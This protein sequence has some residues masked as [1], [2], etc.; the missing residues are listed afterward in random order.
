M[1]DARAAPQ[2]PPARMFGLGKRPW[3][4]GFVV[5]ATV[6]IIYYLLG[7]LALQV[8]SAE[9]VAVFWPASGLAAGAMVVLYPGA[10]WP[11][12]LAVLAATAIANLQARSSIPA[13]VVF[14]LC[15]AA[16]CLIFGRVMQVL[17]R[18]RPHLESLSSVAAFLVAVMLAAGL[19]ALPAAYAIQHL[20]I[21]AA[22]LHNIWQSWFISD[23]IGILTLAPILMTLPAMNERPPR[24]LASLEGLAATMAAVALAYYAFGYAYS[25]I[26]ALTAPTTI[27]LPVSLWLAARTPA[28]YSAMT[29]FLVALVIVIVALIG[30][31]GFGQATMPLADR[32]ISAKVALIATSLT[33][34]TLSAMFARANATATAL[35]SSDQ[36][37][38]L[39]LAGGQIYAFEHDA[40]SRAVHREG[41]LAKRLGLPEVGTIDEYLD[42]LPPADRAAFDDMLHQVSPAEPDIERLLHL[43]SR[44]GRTLLVEYRSRAE[45]DAD[46]RV[47][48]IR[49]T[50]HDITDRERARI[51]KEERE[52][53]VQRVLIAGRVFTF[54]HD[55]ISGKAVR[56]ANAAEILGVPPEKVNMPRD[57]LIKFVH[58]DDRAKLLGSGELLTPQHPF[59]SVSYRFSRPDGSFAWFE[60]AATGTFDADERLIKV[61]G[62]TRDVTEREIARAQLEQ[63]EEQLRSAMDAGRVYAFSFDEINNYVHRSD[64][65][66][67]ILGLPED[68]ARS[69][70]NLMWEH[71]HPDDKVLLAEYESRPSK[72]GSFKTT[73]LRFVRPGGRIA[74]LELSSKMTFN[75][76]GRRVNVRGLVRDVT[77]KVRAEQRQ[78][79]LIKELD[80]RVKNALA[81]MAVVIERSRDHHHTLDE[82]I[83]VIQGRVCSMARTQERLSR[84]KWVGVGIET[85]V[86]DE[87]AAY[88][89]PDNCRIEGPSQLLEPEVAQAF[90]F[91]LHE[92]A[93]NAAKYG[94]LA[95]PNG[96]VVVTWRVTSGETS[97]GIL[98]LTWRETVDGGIEQPKYESYG[99]STIKQQ[100]A[101]EHDAIVALDFTPTGLHYKVELPLPDTAALGDIGP[102]GI[103]EPAVEVA[104]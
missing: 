78:A 100:L 64:N 59:G 22:P 81:R 49:G 70:R 13:T 26:L 92:L 60:V 9:G 66:A 45:F 47:L 17:D 58:P 77:D 38:K 42:A 73:T 51:E 72:A 12:A 28:F 8:L 27:L 57:E 20:G 68:V 61:S 30:D 14:A 1:Q 11:I 6:G 18:T 96:K 62:L 83:S 95:R 71:V 21:S 24:Q 98:E 55:L 2:L 3:R 39:A 16:E 35:R 86:A 10:R 56:S 7:W 34:L 65:A 67:E 103:R 44:D 50:F 101:Y 79:M 87:L 48:R 37:L 53:E 4:D 23:A 25:G 69:A 74:W 41:G 63:R 19:A 102:G 40:I 54:E 104:E 29:A 75:E 90:S 84:S 88:Q 99:L 36:R 76:A 31:S 85:L 80:H 15:N 93:T 91:S 32:L 43:N 89:T 82:Y 94:A 97:G 52:K 33:L 5:F 46:G